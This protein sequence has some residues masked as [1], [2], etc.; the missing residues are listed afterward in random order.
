VGKLVQYTNPAKIVLHLKED[1]S[2]MIV[3][4]KIMRGTWFHDLSWQP[5]Q[6]PEEEYIN[7]I[8]VAV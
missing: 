5:V 7:E 3:G 1:I 6:F 8:F 4:L 2:V